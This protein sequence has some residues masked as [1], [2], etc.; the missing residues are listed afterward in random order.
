MESL[1]QAFRTQPWCN[2]DLKGV[3]V[4]VMPAGLIVPWTGPQDR[5]IA[6]VADI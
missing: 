5:R 2:L 4:A 3:T 1:P 6:A